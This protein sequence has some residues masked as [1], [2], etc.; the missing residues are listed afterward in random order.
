MPAADWWLH[1]NLE[2]WQFHM[3]PNM[4][5]S[6]LQQDTIVIIDSKEED[7]VGQ[8]EQRVQ[9]YFDRLQY[10]AG[11]DWQGSSLQIIPSLVGP[12]LNKVQ[13][14]GIDNEAVLAAQQVAKGI[15]YY[16][17]PEDELKRADAGEV[18]SQSRKTPDERE[19]HGDSGVRK[20]Q[21][22]ERE[23]FVST[24]DMLEAEPESGWEAAIFH[25]EE[26]KKNMTSSHFSGETWLTKEQRKGPRNLGPPID[27]RRK[28][29]N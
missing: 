7:E 29:E 23:E 4:A 20:E 14:W 6:M 3:S 26:D 21:A 22:E 28:R 13:R 24:G 17:L 19:R 5:T 18:G 10:D 9:Q 27:G 16:D 8:G 11:G 1:N 12:M 25:R 2:K 15:I